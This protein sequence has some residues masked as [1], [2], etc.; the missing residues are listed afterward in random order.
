MVSDAELAEKVHEFLRGSDLKKTTNNIVI[1]KLESDFGV[2]LSDKKPFLRN[3]VDR[4]LQS[5]YNF[6]DE[7]DATLSRDDDGNDDVSDSEDEYYEDEADFAIGVHQVNGSPTF[8]GITKLQRY[9]FSSF[10]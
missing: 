9:F 5:Q 4:F 2:D 3:Q 8:K 10:V 1:T 7:E 6:S